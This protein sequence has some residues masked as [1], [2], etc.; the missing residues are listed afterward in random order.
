MMAKL[1][2]KH[3]YHYL[4]LEIE[5]VNIFIKIYY[6]YMYGKFVPNNLICTAFRNIK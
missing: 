6:I 3:I 5:F 4:C 2:A 1:V